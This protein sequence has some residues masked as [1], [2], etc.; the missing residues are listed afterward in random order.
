MLLRFC[1]IQKRW[2]RDGLDILVSVNLP[3]EALDDPRYYD[4]TREAQRRYGIR[5]QRLM[6]EVL[7]TSDAASRDSERRGLE[8]FRALG[9]KLA[10]DDLG[11]GHRSFMCGFC[12]AHRFQGWSNFWRITR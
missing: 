6:L 3:A 10:E 12:S 5:P 7:E 9:I 4:I 8:R 2:L 11:A 1:D